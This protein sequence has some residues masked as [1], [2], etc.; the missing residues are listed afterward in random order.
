MYA[1][2]LAAIAAWCALFPRQSTAEYS[3]SQKVTL[4]IRAQPLADALNEFGRQ[5]GLQI[6][7]YDS[8]VRTQ[9]ISTPLA[10]TFSHKEALQALLQHTGLRYEFVS[11]RAVAVGVKPSS[12]QVKR[13][14]SA[15]FDDAA[16]TSSE[17]KSLS[18]ADPSD[19][20]LLETSDIEQILVTGTH[21]RGAVPV[22]ANLI[23]V[24]R[25]EIDRTGYTT[26]QDVVHALPQ[27]FL[28]GGANEGTRL[29]GGP[30]N[31]N[32]SNGSSFNLRGL[33]PGATL[34]LLNGRR[35]PAAG[36]D[37][38]FVDVASLPVSAIQRI[39]VLL[40]GASA[41][42][43]TDAVGGVINVVLRK[44]YQ[45]AE[46]RLY[47]GAPTQGGA[48]EYS[49]GQTLGGNW[50]GGQ[51]IVTYD[52]H[53]R[54]PLAA[55]DRDAT[56]SQDLRPLGGSDFRGL[57]SNPGTI[58]IGPRTWA[59]PFGQDGSTL[60]TASFTEGT[61]NRF[62][63][64][65]LRQILP[66]QE[67]HSLFGSFTQQLGERLELNV[68]VLASQRSSV[69]TNIG[70]SSRIS[71]PRT[72]AYYVNPTGG[73]GSIGI[74][75]N[76]TDDLGSVITEI[77]VT[78]YFGSVGGTVRLPGAWSLSARADHGRELIDQNN[79]NRPIT[80]A[81]NAALAD[82]NRATAFNPFSDG[83]FTNPDTLERIRGN[84]KFD[85]D[86]RMT[87]ATLAGSGPLATLPGGTLSAAVGAEFREQLFASSAQ[88]LPGVNTFLD[89]DDSRDILAAFLE[90]RVPL[91][92][93][94]NAH[95]WLRRLDISLAARHEQYSD[96]GSATS[97]AAALEWKP[98]ESLTFRLSRTES[99][100]APNLP[101]L[102]ESSNVIFISDVPDQLS[103][104][105][106][107][108]ALVWTGSGNEDLNPEESEAWSVGLDWSPARW[109][110]VK[111]GLTYFDIEYQDRIQSLALRLSSLLQ[112]PHLAEAVTRN[113]TG[114][115]RSLACSRARFSGTQP[116]DCT[117]SPVV[118]L[119]DARPLNATKTNLRGVDLLST[120]GFDAPVGR[121][122][123]SLNAA[124][125]LKLEEAFTTLSPFVD[126]LDT[127]FQPAD[128]RIR[129]SA[130]WAVGPWGIGSTMQYV[131]GYRDTVSTPR[132]KISSW[133]GVD[134]HVRY[135]PRRDD[136]VPSWMRGLSVSLYAAN[137][138]DEGPSFFNN[139]VGIGYDPTNTD[140]QAILGR[141]IRLQF[142]KN[143][144][145]GNIR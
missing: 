127:P 14:S 95:S 9:G 125:L 104:N 53:R 101:S 96:F 122:Q 90:L 116:T 16:S 92:G 99:F 132:R 28:G 87:T 84:Q 64:N 50:A 11:D 133:A 22:G 27:N 26:V 41:I 12:A 72:N 140:S 1:F 103:P 5:S 105:G 128:L 77:D 49:A 102:D 141:T 51:A 111:V 35:L 59:I 45:G 129:G 135:Q 34:V 139:A 73:A 24:D 144:G 3:S 97:P 137:V 61:R 80:A 78:S 124:Y 58:V 71:V 134:V 40:D 130:F 110:S 113:P 23:V 126:L 38:S 82:S 63:A 6:V 47:A 106:M 120:L 85:S 48:R 142:R 145:E 21:I 36:G 2:M 32:T 66:E 89:T 70:S 88:L 57:Q 100:K 98:V 81:L 76:F 79:R 31:I 39:E 108:R 119:L 44:D 117:D 114:E 17:T 42:Y 46:T 123:L 8:V 4:D 15:A 33:G 56:A 69:V 118:A 18:S 107:S 94:S 93:N 13:I 52:Y 62:D 55:R 25:E 29:G 43:G 143:W 37:A 30:T 138:F 10:G 109:P 60:T 112:D 86:S 68:D 83:S 131:D 91:F 136:A 75:Y 19:I 67:R 7:Y 74:D 54:D 121:M 65:Q 20:P 115:Q